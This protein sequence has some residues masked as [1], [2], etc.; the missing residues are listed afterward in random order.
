MNRDL[1][2]YIDGVADGMGLE[3]EWSIDLKKGE[4]A[5]VE[6]PKDIDITP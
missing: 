2:F 1:K 6:R 3:G 4:F 5:K